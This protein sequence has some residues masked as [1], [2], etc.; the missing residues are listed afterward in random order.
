MNESIN[1]LRA[2]MDEKI[3][4]K[5]EE[6]RKEMKEEINSLRVEIKDLNNKIDSR[7]TWIIGLII[8][9]WLIPIIIRFLFP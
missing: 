7:F 3:D 5:V 1:G 6:L 9:S 2:E 4:K 8:V